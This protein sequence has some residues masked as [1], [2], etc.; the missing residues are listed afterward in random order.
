MLSNFF[1]DN[2]GERVSSEQAGQMIMSCPPL[3]LKEMTGFTVRFV[4]AS[5]KSNGKPFSYLSFTATFHD[6]TPTRFEYFFRGY[7]VR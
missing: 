4:K 3:H 2:F 5:P 7:N 1:R 6:D